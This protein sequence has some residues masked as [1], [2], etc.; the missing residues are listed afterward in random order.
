M[1]VLPITTAFASLSGIMLV[2]LSIPVSRRRFGGRVALGY[3]SDQVLHAR[4][5]AQ[6]NFCEYM[7]FG[8]ALVGLS[9]V[10][11]LAY[12]WVLASAALLLIGRVIHAAG[13]WAAPSGRRRTSIRLRATGIL[14]TWG[15][16]ALDSLGLLY[17]L[18]RP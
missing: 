13:M 8:L 15:V 6:A 16:L 9:E 10:N 1:A 3:G 18:F 12:N 14:L 4:M 17:R 7:P 5:R 2:L 11:G